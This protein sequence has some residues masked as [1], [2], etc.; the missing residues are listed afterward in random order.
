MINETFITFYFSSQD[1]FLTT[2]AQKIANERKCIRHRKNTYVF[3]TRLIVSSGLS[4]QFFF[5]H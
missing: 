3:L 2:P 4:L 1:I 5:A